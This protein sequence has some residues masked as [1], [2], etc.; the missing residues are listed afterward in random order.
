MCWA[1]EIHGHKSVAAPPS[2]EL[3]FLGGM[4]G[5][6]SDDS[7]LQ[8]HG[9]RCWALPAFRKTLVDL[10]V[11][12]MA[13]TAEDR[14]STPRVQAAALQVQ[15]HHSLSPTPHFGRISRNH[16]CGSAGKGPTCNAGDLGSIPGLGRSP[17]E[18]KGYPL[19]YSGLENSMDCVAHGVVKSRTRRS[20][21]HFRGIILPTWARGWRLIAGPRWPGRPLADRACSRAGARLGPWALAQPAAALPPRTPSLGVRAVSRSTCQWTAGPYRPSSRPFK[22]RLKFG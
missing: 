14:T 20:N 2:E 5:R 11:P 7:F 3:E 13:F 22:G 19:Q 6:G 9:E 17:G 16:P 15:L 10:L 18:G 12:R 1:S 4:G 21:F 8:H